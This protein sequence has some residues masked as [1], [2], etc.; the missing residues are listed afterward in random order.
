MFT[1]IWRTIKDR[2]YSIIVF[3]A[4]GV[5]L[6]WLYVLLFPAM[7]EMADDFLKVLE[8]YPEAFMNMFPITEATFANIENFLAMEQYSL[9]I[10]I[11][12]IFMLVAMAAV[13]L[14]GEVERGTAEILL[15]RP[16]SRLKIFFARYLVGIF[17]LIVFIV[18]STI[19]IIPL[20]ELHNV[21]YILENFISISIL[22]FVFGWAVF[23]IA[24]MLSAIFSERSRV[25]MI[26]GG[27][28]VGMYVLQIIASISEKWENLQYVSFFYY[29]DY[30]K[31]LLDNSLDA[32]NIILFIGVAIICTVVGAYLFNK[33]DVAVQ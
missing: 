4:A 1:I 28:M 5:L 18:A 29:Y 13:G 3:S 7:Q 26:M 17:A 27:L 32:L 24:I 33:R 11:L 22:C 16:V 30:E 2:K 23:S 12:I 6:L 25:Y 14:A 20:G 21:D 31:A 9:M 15:S 10:P 8:G 19:M